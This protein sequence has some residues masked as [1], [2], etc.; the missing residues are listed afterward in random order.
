MYCR[1]Y[2]SLLTAVSINYFGRRG[3]KEGV[4]GDDEQKDNSMTPFL[5]VITGHKNINANRSF[6]KRKTGGCVDGYEQ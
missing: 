5:Q 4:G 6:N 3:I 1:N 2:C